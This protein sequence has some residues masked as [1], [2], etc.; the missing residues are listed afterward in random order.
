MVSAIQ[1]TQQAHLGLERRTSGRSV[2]CANDPALARRVLYN[3]D[4]KVG[5][6]V[7]APQHVI[8]VEARDGD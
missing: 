2:G 6:G 1:F 3:N 5:V 8:H 7:R 4:V